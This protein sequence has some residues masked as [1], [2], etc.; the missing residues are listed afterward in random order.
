[1]AS[2]YKLSKAEFGLWS[3]SI[4]LPEVSEDVNMQEDPSAA[5]QVVKSRSFDLQP[6][7]KKTGASLKQRL[8]GWLTRE[9]PKKKTEKRERRVNDQP[10][11]THRESP[12]HKRS[13]LSGK[14]NSTPTEVEEVRGKPACRRAII[15]YVET[16][17]Q[18]KA[19]PPSSNYR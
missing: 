18:L 10:S 1:M 16:V 11:T 15:I 13:W 14:S 3:Y 6:E 12:L 4:A 5:H 2:E 7:E 17:L 19:A 9:S 8:K